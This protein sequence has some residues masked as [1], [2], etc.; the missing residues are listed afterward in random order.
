MFLKYSNLNY[1]SNI[2]MTWNF[3]SSKY[4]YI[5]LKCH[6]I[7]SCPSE[8]I[9]PGILCQNSFHLFIYIHCFS[10]LC[11]LSWKDFVDSI[12]KN[13]YTRKKTK[14][15]KCYSTHWAPSMLT[16]SGQK[17]NPCSFHAHCML[18]S[19]RITTITINTEPSNAVSICNV[20]GFRFFPKRLFDRIITFTCVNI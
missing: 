6:Y 19:R 2:I 1:F 5:F 4:T 16:V 14:P 17:N 8:H 13:V 15:I 18:V 11:F 9:K 10:V 7:S 20:V 3:R 12:I